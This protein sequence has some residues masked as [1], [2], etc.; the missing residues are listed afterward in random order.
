MKRVFLTI[1]LVVAVAIAGAADAPRLVRWTGSEPVLL[2]PSSRIRLG[3]GGEIRL[4]IENILSAKYHEITWFKNGVAIPGASGAV[5]VL[6]D[7]QDLASGTY[8]ASIKTPCAV[9]S[10]SPVDV[11]VE[12]AGPDI[13]STPQS[14]GFELH[15]V[16]PNPVSDKAVIRFSVPAPCKVHLRVVDVVGNAVA[17][18]LNTEVTAGAHTSEFVVGGA[19]IAST[20]YYVVLSTPGFKTSQP[21]MVVK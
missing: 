2:E 8:T 18:I 7:V 17:T 20:L 15:P 10:S 11:V 9:R 6:T 12:E 5:L 1:S 13:T 21:M 4:G 19:E 14:G 16:H 3:E